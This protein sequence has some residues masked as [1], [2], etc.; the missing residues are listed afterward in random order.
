MSGK[1]VYWLRAKSPP[2]L[3]PSNSIAARQARKNVAENVPRF[4]FIG[5]RALG[6]KKKPPE[7]GS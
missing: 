4:S 7:G 5:I 6:K 2:T 3:P 1:S